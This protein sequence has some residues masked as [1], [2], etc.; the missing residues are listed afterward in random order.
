M[1]DD[2]HNRD[3]LA[4]MAMLKDHDYD[5]FMRVLYKS[6]ESFPERIKTDPFPLEHRILALKKVLKYF[7][8]DDIQEFEKCALLKKIIDELEKDNISSTGE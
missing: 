6:I 3:N 7:E 4:M 5:S 8:N 1:K 2:L